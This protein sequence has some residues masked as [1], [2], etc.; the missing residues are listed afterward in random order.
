[1]YETD[2]G[3]EITNCWTW[4]NGDKTD[5]DAIYQQKMKKKM[6][7]YQGNGNGYNY[8]FEKSGTTQF[9]NN[10][11]FS[12]RGSLDHEF[13]SD[14]IEK[15]NSW[16]LKVNANAGDFVGLSE[17]LA[18]APRNADGSLPSN[19]FAKLV[20]GSDLIDKGIGIGLPYLG[21]APDLGAY[22]NH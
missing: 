17:E 20:D 6:S 22:E 4:H 16:N 12:V 8:M 13:A 5:F 1:M 2:W 19:G 14:A 7:S 21:A 10:I 9:I 18:K 11:S 3:I 15:N